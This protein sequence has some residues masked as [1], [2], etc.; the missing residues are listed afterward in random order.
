MNTIFTK[1]LIGG[2]A[3]LLAMTWL[4]TGLSA[5]AQ[6]AELETLDEQEQEIPAMRVHGPITTIRSGALVFAGFDTNRDYIISRAEAAMGVKDAFK[7]A[8]KDGSARL[9]LFELEDW[10]VAAL[11][12]LDALPGNL[13][14]DA[15]YNNQ[16]TA[17]EFEAGMMV[18]FDRHDENSDGSL[19]HAE[20]MSILEVPRRKDPQQERM[21]DRQC[22][23]QIQRNRG[24]Y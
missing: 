16:I 7:R 12:S 4:S 20:L 13:S 17:A 11:G 19:K 5:N 9:S 15:D 14:F 23:D 1:A 22:A 2:S 3:F 10:R 8:D 6:D 21:T 24:R 18:V